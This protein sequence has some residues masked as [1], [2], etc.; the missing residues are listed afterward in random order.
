MCLC[1]KYHAEQ[2]MGFAHSLLDINQAQLNL[3]IHGIMP[4]RLEY[5]V[6]RILRIIEPIV[7]REWGLEMYLKS[8]VDEPVVQDKDLRQFSIKSEDGIALGDL[9]TKTISKDN[10]TSVKPEKFLLYHKANESDVYNKT[11]AYKFNDMQYIRTSKMYPDKV[12]KKRV[13]IK[14]WQIR[15]D[16]VSHKL[17]SI[18]QTF[19]TLPGN[20]EVRTKKVT[21]TNTGERLENIRT[22]GQTNP[23]TDEMVKTL[24]I[25]SIDPSDSKE[26]HEFLAGTGR[27]KI[28]FSLSGLDRDTLRYEWIETKGMYNIKRGEN[29]PGNQSVILRDAK[30]TKQRG[31]IRLLRVSR[32]ANGYLH[33][34]G[35]VAALILD[36]GST[37]M[38]FHFDNGFPTAFGEVPNVD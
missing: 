13:K 33:D 19:E 21:D 15:E 4:K 26:T 17:I 6:K 34:K 9:V 37:T 11:T 32:D 7:I 35:A 5:G 18:K 22:F 3:T 31:K 16:P 20:R 2:L 29:L 38:H 14:Q 8:K 25:K 10:K 30:V 1:V 28:Q 12:T 27:I 36:N 23:M 24:H